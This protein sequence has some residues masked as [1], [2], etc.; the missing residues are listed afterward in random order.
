LGNTK[1]YFQKGTFD[2]FDLAA[3]A[4]GILAAYMVIITQRKRRQIS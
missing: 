4:F 2:I 3:I 1:I